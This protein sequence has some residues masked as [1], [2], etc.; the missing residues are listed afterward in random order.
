MTAARHPTE[1]RP[2]PT[3][4]PF[5]A[6]CGSENVVRDAWA[7]WDADGQCWTLAV[8]FD[9]AECQDCGTAT[10]IDWAPTDSQPRLKDPTG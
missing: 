4:R 3:V 7:C 1:P 6:A 2:E 10:T 5:C 8:V 9:H